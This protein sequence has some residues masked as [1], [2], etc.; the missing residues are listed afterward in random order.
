MAHIARGISCLNS[1]PLWKYFN[2]RFSNTRSI[3]IQRR[4]FIKALLF[5]EI[6]VLVKSL[7][8]HLDGTLNLTSIVIFKNFKSRCAL[9][10]NLEYSLQRD[11]VVHLTMV[12][13]IM[14]VSDFFNWWVSL[15]FYARYSVKSKKSS[16]F[17]LD[18]NIFTHMWEA[19]RWG[20][21]INFSR[22]WI[23]FPSYQISFV[24]IEKGQCWHYL[25]C[26]LSRD[27]RQILLC[28]RLCPTVRTRN[29][30]IS[31]IRKTDLTLHILNLQPACPL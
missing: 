18:Y 25:C 3:Q 24:E 27:A 28:S 17:W 10:K 15:N 30:V 9:S 16:R 29:K 14:G 5:T 23:G 12:W 19:S 6:M 21:I 26:K 22:A 4:N 7:N 11:R 1:S 31:K 2:K 13:G 20:N 8:F